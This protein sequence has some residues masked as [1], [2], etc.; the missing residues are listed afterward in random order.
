MFKL[1]DVV[2]DVFAGVGPFSVPAAKK[3]CA[4]LAND[5]NPDSY[6]YLQLNIRQNKVSTGTRLC[7]HLHT[8][9]YALIGAKPSSFLL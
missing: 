8:Y 4:V 3:G 2:A 7:A 1:E 9:F 6:E 5:L